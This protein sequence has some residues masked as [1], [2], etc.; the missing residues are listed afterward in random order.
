MTIRNFE[1]RKGNGNDGCRFS[2]VIEFEENDCPYAF[3]DVVIANDFIV[4]HRARS[5]AYQSVMVDGE[6]DYTI[7]ATL[8][9]G[10][11]GETDMGAAYK[12][13]ELRK[14]EDVSE[15]ETYHFSSVKNYLDRG[16]YIKYK[17]LMK[18][19]G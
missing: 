1:L 15:Y 3:M 14:V 16:A 6:E 10:Y 7:Y 19:R 13:A 17:K 9:E 12:C 2:Q 4:G 18:E 5:H 11:R 8:H